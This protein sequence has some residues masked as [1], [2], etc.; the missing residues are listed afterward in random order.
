MLIKSK[1]PPFITT[2]KL[3]DEKYGGFF[4]VFSKEKGKIKEK[5]MGVYCNDNR[6]S[7]P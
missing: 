3:S 5:G 2:W 1:L 7:K 6:K 4:C